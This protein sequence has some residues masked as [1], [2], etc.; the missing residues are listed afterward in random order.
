MAKFH[1]RYLICRPGRDGGLPRWFWQPSSALRAEGW[2]AQRVPVDWETHTDAA[3]L[4]RAAI[5]RAEELNAELDAARQRNTLTG[6]RPAQPQPGRTVAEL[7]KAFQGSQDWTDLAP[8][9]RRGYL[10]C[11]ARIEAWAGDA[12]VRA[13]DAPRVQRF[14]QSM[15]STPAFANACLRVLRLLL[16]HG[17]RAGWI[18]I[19]PALRPRLRGTDPSG[20]I[21]PRQAVQDFI[22]IADR[23]GY[24]SI[25]TAVA[26]NE[27]TGQRQ[28]D[29]LRM[30]RSALVNGSL[31]IRQNKT[32]AGVTL[33]IGMVAVLNTRVT[34]EIDRGRTT[35][36]AAVQAAIKA[37]RPVPAEPITILV[38][39]STGQAW[40]QDHFRHAFA[41]IRA[42]LAKQTPSYRIEHLMPGR[43]AAD[44]DAFT[45]RTSE[46]T[47][48]QLRHT[49]VT[50]LGEAG[51]DP[52]LISTISGHALGSVTHILER[53]LVRTAVMARLAFQN[54]L[55]AE[56]EHCQTPKSDNNSDK[57]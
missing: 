14:G 36:R 43:D 8:A 9:T 10:Q 53:Y 32:G 24:P 34:E 44:Q 29:V 28:A 5:A 30:T 17:R 22:A 4:Q 46:L 51:C 26:M 11:L 40:K 47:F 42:T 38:C 56:E 55:N 20:L 18:T 12:P 37:R 50:R 15:A 49:A 31:L 16:E 7:C 3:A 27:W 25:G 13:L 33:P 52:Q 45:V 35:H 48:M 39:E 21:W 1:T 57:V 23:L 54:R 2:A 41:E 6:A 19:N